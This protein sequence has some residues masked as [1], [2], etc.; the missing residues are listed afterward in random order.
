M[1]IPQAVPRPSPATRRVA[2]P[3]AA[4][5]AGTAALTVVT[6]GL[7]LP[8]PLVT[9]LGLLAMAA[10]VAAWLALGAAAGTAGVRRL[11]AVAAG[12]ALPLL[13]ARPL[14][15]GD[16]WSYLAQGLITARGLDPYR[17]GPAQAL[18]PDS[19]VTARVSAYWRDTPAPYGPGWEALSGAVARL[20]GAHPVAGVVAYRVVAVLGV[21]LIAWALPRLAR[22]AGVG[23]SRAV[24]LGL[25]NRWCCGTWWRGC[26]TRR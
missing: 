12:W 9:A 24:W 23:A 22:R 18:G 14:F 1:S 16:V 6:A 3:A 10:V 8:A 19:P 17:L 4:G 5:V 7:P 26:T 2:L 20:T 11:Y 15:S 13:A 21:V 25:L